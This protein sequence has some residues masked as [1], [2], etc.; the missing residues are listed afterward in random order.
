MGHS[1]NKYN[2]L[3]PASVNVRNIPAESIGIFQVF[4]IKHMHI[5]CVVFWK[6]VSLTEP[7]S[8]CPVFIADIVWKLRVIFVIKDK[9]M[10]DDSISS[11]LRG[12]ESKGSWISLFRE[13]LTKRK[14]F[15]FIWNSEMQSC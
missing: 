7:N 8:R 10:E 6:S 1:F 14:E 13:I 11:T 2:G 3:N 4:K 12:E 5:F 9:Q 15:T